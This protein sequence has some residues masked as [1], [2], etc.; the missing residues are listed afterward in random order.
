MHSQCL[1][2]EV[3]MA[4]TTSLHKL[5]VQEAQNAQM[6]QNGATFVSETSNDHTGKF[7]AITIVT[8][9]IFTTLTA[10]DG[11]FLYGTGSGAGFDSN[12][13]NC[14]SVTFPAGITIYGRW[15]TFRLASGSVIAYRG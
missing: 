9:T 14:A 11:D 12:G 3:K 10:L 8:D 15:K 5:T 2:Q 13:S 4:R 1:G 6:G 7:V